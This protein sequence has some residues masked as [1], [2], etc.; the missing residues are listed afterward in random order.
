[1]KKKTAPKKKTVKAWAIV[2]KIGVCFGSGCNHPDC[3]KHDD[4][5]F[6]MAVADKKHHVS[7]MKKNHSVFYKGAKIVSVNI[8][9]DLP[10]TK[11]D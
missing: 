1:M 2:D 4:C 9:Y 8:T 3:L 11:R 7:V 10:H 6:T 5:G